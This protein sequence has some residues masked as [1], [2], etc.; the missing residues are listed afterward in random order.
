MTSKILKK[1]RTWYILFRIRR[2]VIKSHSNEK[3]GL[4]ML[5]YLIPRFRSFLMTTTFLSIKISKISVGSLFCSVWSHLKPYFCTSSVVYDFRIVVLWLIFSISSKIWTLDTNVNFLNKK[6]S[7]IG[8]I[9]TPSCKRG[10]IQWI[11]F[12][13]KRFQKISL[14]LKQNKAQSGIKYIFKNNPR[15]KL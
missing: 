9:F 1:E 11:I 7:V 15:L 8:K 2:W 5:F 6:M 12:E 4:R 14:R 13:G 3:P 10:N